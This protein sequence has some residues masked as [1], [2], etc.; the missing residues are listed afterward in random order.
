M[1]IFKKSL[2]LFLVLYAS[3]HLNLFSQSLTGTSGLITI[4]TAEILPDG[5]IAFGMNYNNKKYVKYL[6]G[7]YSAS[8]YFAAISFLPFLEI[9]I[10]V[11]RYMDFPHGQ[12]LG[13]RGLSIRGK[14]L[15][16]TKTIP[17]VV[18]GAH[19]FLETRDQGT[20]KLSNALYIVTSKH[21]EINSN[22]NIAGLHLGYGTDWIKSYA[23]HFLGLFGGISFEHKKILKGMIE[24]DGERFNCGTEITLFNHIK[25]LAGLME[26]NTFSGG[27]CYKAQLF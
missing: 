7:K 18:I 15:N 1:K 17:S 26:F 23:H 21:F 20:N 27:I 24:Y 16:E 5:E 22:N 11:T 13:D 10:K 9:G 6:D 8:N 25:I 14:F 4:P 19:D 3:L 12:A 2:S